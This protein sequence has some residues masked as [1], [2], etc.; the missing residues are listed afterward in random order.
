MNFDLTVIGAGINGAAVAHAAAA[1]GYRV[2]VLEQCSEA[3]QG[4]SSKSS[5]L[6][7]GG[8]RYLESAEFRLVR[9]CLKERKHLL[10]QHPDLVT[11][12]PFYIPVYRQTSR[13]PWLIASGLSLYTLLGGKGFRLLPKREWPTLNG[14]RTND[15]RAV[16]RYWD[17]RTDD[18][19]LTERIISE[20]ACKGTEI[21]YNA[22]F[23]S[24]RCESNVCTV[25]F[26]K[27]G[28][29][30]SLTSRA[31]INAA[32]PWVN[33]VLKCI[34]PVVQPLGIDLVQGT[35]I[36]VPGTL[37]DRVFYLETPQD[38][39]AVFAMPWK[40]RIMIGTTETSYLGD[41][42][43]VHPREDEI[44]YL[45]ETWNHHFENQ[46]NRDDVIDSFA[47]LRVLPSSEGSAFKRSRETRIHKDL[48]NPDVLSI[49]G[50]KLT[51][52]RNT[53]KDVLNLLPDSM[54]R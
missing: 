20:A 30:H 7:H 40:D 46:L 52:H 16:F 19:Q 26:T 24:A 53:A 18:K 29:E 10:S 22:V 38:Q 41:P 21:H 51:S 37:G 9:E 2:V 44:S 15:L 3:A 12:A 23:Q 36:I 1:N 6:I 25:T 50:G 45:L 5:K 32:G 17:A 48:S 8:L 42:A 11:L 28:M 54:H 4:T 31:L 14:L 49:Y 35:H 43:Q 13:S 34:T 47:G 39:R 33:D 27:N